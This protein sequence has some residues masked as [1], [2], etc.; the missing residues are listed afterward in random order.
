MPSRMVWLEKRLSVGHL[1]DVLCD[2]SYKRKMGFPVCKV[3]V[4]AH[5]VT[6]FGEGRNLDAGRPEHAQLIF[7]RRVTDAPHAVP[8]P[9]IADRVIP[10]LH[11]DYK[12]SRIKQYH[13]E[14]RALAHRDGGQRRLRL[15]HRQAA[16]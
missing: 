4:V 3:F 9:V 7:D 10:S 8:N 5:P 15:R 6:P 12:H 13:K 1:P 14:V 16:A 11:V 2:F